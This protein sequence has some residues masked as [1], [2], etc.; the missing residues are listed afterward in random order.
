M[1]QQRVAG[2]YSGEVAMA[3]SRTRHPIAGLGVFAA[4]MFREGDV[5]GPYYGMIV[6]QDLSSRQSTRE[7]YV[8]GVLEV[9]V[10][11]FFRHALELRVQGR[12]WTG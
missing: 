1:E 2:A 3:L 5:I 11:G 6:Y 9:D 12:R 8:D 7:V 10:E 4:R